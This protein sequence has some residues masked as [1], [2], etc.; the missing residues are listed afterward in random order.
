MFAA[1]FDTPIVWQKHDACLVIKHAQTEKARYIPLRYRSAALSDLYQSVT[2][3][4]TRTPDMCWIQNIHTCQCFGDLEPAYTAQDIRRCPCPRIVR[5]YGLRR[6]CRQCRSSK[7][8]HKRNNSKR[9]AISQPI[10]EGCDPANPINNTRM[11]RQDTANEKPAIASGEHV[12]SLTSGTAL[13]EES[14]SDPK[15][16]GVVQDDLEAF[17][18]ST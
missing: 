14:R 4:E 6:H 1:L 17:S 3:T 7:I 10:H 15:R 9:T 13:G 8:R 5:M 16:P 18:S 11:R 2:C 12:L